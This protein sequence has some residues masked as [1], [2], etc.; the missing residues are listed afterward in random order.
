MG[1]IVGEDGK[2]LMQEIASIRR[3]I[4]RVFYGGMLRNEDDTLLARGGSKGLKIYE[5]LK[6]DSHAGSV[7]GKRK[8][9]VTSRPWVVDP[10][11]DRREDKKA[12]DLVS[13][14]LKH[15]RFNSVCKRLLEATLKGYAVSEVMW[16][17]RD[18]YVM[19]ANVIGRDPRRF[20]FS[21]ENELHLRTRENMLTGEPMPPRKFIVHRRGADDDNPYGAG[22][23][24]ML[25]WPVFFK[26]NGITFWLTF[27]DKFGSPTLL[28]KYPT[29][30]NQKE[31][32]DLLKVLQAV[33]QDAGIIV[34][35]GMLIEMLEAK[36]SGGV[37]TYEKLVRYMDE[38]ISI[39]VLG[40]TM[41][42]TAA[43]SGLGSNQADV[44]NGVRMEVAQDDA[45]ELDETLN[46]TL[47]R[48]IVEFNFPGAGLP[49]LRRDF[50]EPEDLVQRATR[51][52]TLSD[53]GWEPDQEYFDKT[54]GKGWKRK[55][56]P[57]AP[58][59]QQVNQQGNSA[60][61]Q[62]LANAAADPTEAADDPQFADPQG[63]PMQ[64]A[65]GLHAVSQQALANAAEALS[66]SWKKLVGRRVEDLTT[67]LENTGDL[68][69]FREGITRLVDSKPD[70]ATVETI[71]R[72]TFA[73]HVIG[74]G[75]PA[76]QRG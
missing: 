19:P 32:S 5:E 20:L 62:L 51:D 64:Q 3:D 30:S 23:G 47:V 49:T 56:P 73:A 44:Q 74:R 10:A 2:P 13:A 7:L 25:F 52:K 12:A 71:A 41:S 9:A 36:R 75:K 63:R 68:V 31:Q 18:G 40:E 50:E 15:L 69:Q 72:S 67:M 26:R 11:S 39:A 58:V 66:E 16:E 34:P 70:P 35:E 43:A 14:A 4:N 17:L 55:P 48:W 29:G 37:D 27:A 59:I 45:N 53:M 33:S 28:G 60:P 46:D 8:L 22:I 76:K 54:Y 65:R 21:V 1:T 6:R 38:Q 42:T 61:E 24:N 57:A